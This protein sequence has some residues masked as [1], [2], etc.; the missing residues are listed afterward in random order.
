VARG[1][2]GRRDAPRC[3][4]VPMK[5]PARARSVVACAVALVLLAGAATVAVVAVWWNEFEIH[6]VAVSLCA[7]PGLDG[8][9]G[10]ATRVMV[11]SDTHLLGPRGH[12]LDRLRREHAMAR[13]YAEAVAQLRPDAVLH[14]GDLTDEG[15]RSGNVAWAEV[16]RRAH[17]VFA[18]PLP[19]GV[20]LHVIPGNHDVGEPGE[21]ANQHEHGQL[22]ERWGRWEEEFGRTDAVFHVAGIPFVVVN[23]VA[24]E[25][26]GDPVA[27]PWETAPY[28]GSPP[29]APSPARGKLGLRK[30]KAKAKAK[31]E[32]ESFRATDVT[33][34]ARYFLDTLRAARDGGARVA[35]FY[36]GRTAH[37]RD[38]ATLRG[39]AGASSPPPRPI[40]LTHMPLHRAGE[41]L[42]AQDE[43]D[44]SDDAAYGYRDA[45][46][47]GDD[48]LS[49]AVTRRVLEA[50]A[51]RFVL[52][53]HTHRHCRS[54]ADPAVS[55]PRPEEVTV[56]TF[57]WRNRD[58]PSFVLLE[59]TATKVAAAKCVAPRESLVFRAYA[60]AGAIVV[61]LVAGALPLAR[62]RA[63]DKAH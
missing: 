53:G 54:P 38:A 35:D 37:A 47:S 41:A 55:P 62:P 28:V 26:Q 27:R 24:L 60:A 9:G 10:V 58:D 29:S 45:Y 51:P 12:W 42:C 18:A 5:P 6:R 11:V 2:V 32:P 31:A 14:L 30:A 46:I 25:V 33:R 7:W 40:L 13:V 23:A 34:T 17:R 44:V 57:S 48:V 22:H 52:S 21:R 63:K 59:A 39:E 4:S 16:M 8:D 3:A 19:V 20:P 15:S 43:A 36:P 56:S 50:V 49:E 61:A 1:G